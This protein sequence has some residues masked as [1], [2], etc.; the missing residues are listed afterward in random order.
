MDF[1]RTLNELLKSDFELKGTSFNRILATAIIAVMGYVT[2]F[3]YKYVIDIELDLYCH[4]KLSKKSMFVKNSQG[5]EV[6]VQSLNRN[7]HQSK[8]HYFML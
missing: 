5:D 4:V 6:V 8:T 3:N 7:M 2:N 1:K